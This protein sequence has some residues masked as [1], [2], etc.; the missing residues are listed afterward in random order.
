[1]LQNV[2]LGKIMQDQLSFMSTFDH[3]RRKS[4]CHIEIL[5]VF[6]LASKIG[7]VDV[8]KSSQEMLLF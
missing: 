8:Q 6:F 5:A 1:M 3:F 7:K 4:S 2:V